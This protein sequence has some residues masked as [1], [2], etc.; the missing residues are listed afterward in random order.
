MDY[1]ELAFSAS[2]YDCTF[3]VDTGADISLIKISS[4]KKNGC[5]NNKEIIKITGVGKEP[6]FTLGVIF[7]DLSVK[8]FK[9]EHKYHVV[10]DDFNIPSEGI[11]G[12]DFIKRFRSLIDYDSM[13]ITL[14]INEARVII[15]I[16]EGHTDNAIT[17]PARSEVVRRIDL[18]NLKGTQVIESQELA[19][20]IYIARAIVES[21]CPIVRIINTTENVATL[22]KPKLITHNLSDYEVHKISSLENQNKR[23]EKLF[24]V[25][26]KNVP[27]HAKNLLFPLCRQYSDIFTL[28]G[29]LMTTN[30][31]YQQ[32]LN[33]I[34]D[35]PV[36]IKNY[37]LP[38]TQKEEIRN[39]VNK[40][41]KNKLIEPSTSNY[42]SP[43]LLVP[44]KSP[45][46]T[47]KWRLCLDYRQI[48]KK[49]VADKFPLPRIDDML[50][51]LVRAKYFSCLDLYA[52]F[53][54]IE[55]EPNSRDITSFSTDRGSYR[56][57][58]LPFGLNVSPNSF[59]RMMAIAFSGL[60]PEQAFL[61]I[62]D[63]IVVGCSEQHHLKNLKAV[64]DVCRK[65]NL[66]LNPEKCEFFKKEVIYLGHKCTSEGL[67]PDDSKI[68]AVKKFPVPKDKDATRRFVAFANYYRRFIEHFA[69][70]ARPLNRL[71]R[72]RV[73]FEWTE[74]CEKSFKILK[75]KMINAPILQYPDF[76][77]PFIITVDASNYACGAVLSQN[78]NQEDLPI[79]FASRGFNKAE[80]NKS[81]IE[82]E[83]M[84]I[85][86][87]IKQFRPYIFGTKFTVRSDHRPLIYLFNMKD[88]SSKLTR[89]RLDLEEYNFTI[90]YIKGKKNVVADALS[91]INIEDIKS[92]SVLPVITRSMNKQML[93]KNTTENSKENEQ[94]A[95]NNITV[96][97]QLSSV[98]DKNIPRIRSY[99]LDASLARNK[100]KIRASMRHKEIFTIQLSEFISN[101]KLNLNSILSKLQEK[102]ANN[103]ITK[104]Q[105]PLNDCIFLHFT[106]SQFKE[107]CIKYL[108]NLQI[109]LIKAPKVVEKESEIRELLNKYHTDPAYGG[110]VGQKRLYAKLRS[111]YYWKNMSKDIARFVRDCNKCQLNKVKS[112]NKE[113]LV[114][115]QTPQSA[116]DV[117]IV[118]TIG[119]LP[120]S[121][122]GNQYAITIT[123][124]LTKYLVTIPIP[125]KE[126]ATVARA[127]VNN[128]ILVYSP[129]R[130]IRTD[131]GTEY[132]NQTLKHLF[133]ILKVDHQTSTAYRH[134]T[135]GTAERSHRVFNEYLRAYLKDYSEWEEYLRYFTFCH[136]I[137]P[138]SALNHKFTPF[139]LV[140][141]RKAI[142]PDKLLD[143]NIDPLYNIDNYA[144]ESKY[145]LQCAHKQA[146]ELLHKAKLTSKSYA[147]K[148]AKPLDININ[149][150]VV[151]LKEPRTKHESLYSGPFVVKK[152]QNSNVVIM[153][154][155]AKK[156][157]LV[158]KNRLRKYIQ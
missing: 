9:I 123:C 144:L 113:P 88:P 46:G 55:I 126:A 151:L 83:L 28:E 79:Y 134:E 5:I 18:G 137:T 54:Q 31:F 38:H 70:I 26:E 36:Y 107:A 95:K 12:R 128:F 98:I 141:S 41:L 149:D 57:K 89:I 11:L 101:E 157:K 142:I 121:N 150:K 132:V 140:F 116:F 111:E 66:K 20:G 104:I 33:L 6:I 35:T 14:K 23:T 114:I 152:L 103:S 80:L 39:Q 105:W 51:S 16:R 92:S 17:L 147:D 61:Y 8:N 44:K 7:A 97:T 72:K 135:L 1:V 48:N 96:V 91:R 50:D 49:L 99:N 115:T 15:P 43:L 139:E 30:N 68:E 156:E 148:T 29:D 130:Q 42:N 87:A 53:H 155:N 100:P 84:A 119:P 21:D 63:I 3:L 71:T 154:E 13:T 94:N 146:Q 112:A 59:S 52:G 125:N 4:L 22:I 73:D 153:D 82:K 65:H 93:S 81:T 67:L 32:K 75:E 74:E 2:G 69:D 77:Q 76:K 10:P 108:K 19:K 47:K 145:R 86:F 25:V 106:V 78:R 122:Q 131:L 24:K 120:K 90:E 118:D 143:N 40:L 138:S 85:H 110:H 136:N 60:E 34:D 133:E 129:M 102:A 127:I 64:F 158:H 109:L 27:N 124:D 45:D 62:D 37:R 58:V 117:V 56:W